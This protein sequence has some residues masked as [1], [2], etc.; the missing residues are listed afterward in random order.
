MP[1]DIAPD[2]GRTKYGSPRVSAYYAVIGPPP[3]CGP[4]DHATALGYLHKIEAAIV[5]GGWSP[6]ENIRLKKL[7]IKWSRRAFGRDP[8]FD[9]VGT[10]EG[11]LSADE[12]HALRPK[13]VKLR[14]E[15]KRLARRG[16]LQDQRSN[17]DRRRL[18]NADLPVRAAKGTDMSTD[19]EMEHDDPESGDSQLPVIPAAR[20]YLIPG[21]DTKG[22]A[23]RI[24]CRVMPAHYRALC[25]LERS[26]GFGFRTVGDVVRWCV[27]Y[28]VRELSHRANVPQTRS[29]LA[30]VDAIRE[31]LLDEQYYL[32]FPQTFELMTTVINKHLS[33]GAETEA[34]RLIA[35]VRHQ[36]EQMSE[37]FWRE[38]F[39][40]ELMRHY[41]TYLDG[42][43]TAG[44]SFGG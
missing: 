15:E 7:A 2:Y 27:D 23:H 6:W 29:A 26:K 34:V 17:P 21:Q 24:Y 14:D 19:G 44:A 31:I 3:E 11:R 35:M 36:I 43:R 1:S 5:Q 33:A 25:A 41:G 4:S 22:H 8:R 30:Q 16:R 42:S 9:A 39:M 32:E 18:I 10:R 37:E 20:Q 28:G 12:E 38:K 13:V 40:A